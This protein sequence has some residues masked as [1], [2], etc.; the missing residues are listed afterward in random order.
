LETEQE[1]RLVEL[2]VAAA[3]VVARHFAARVLHHLLEGDLLLVQ[4]A[5]ERAGTQAELPRDVRERG[6][7]SGER[8]P[9]RVPDPVADAGVPVPRLE[10]HVQLGADHGEQVRVA[11]DERPVEIALPEYDRVPRPPEPDGAAEVALQQFA[12]PRG[13]RELE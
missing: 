4:A 2:N 13:P 3:Q 6:P 9:D 12:L 1:R 5:L 10:F 11:G 8:A 7:P